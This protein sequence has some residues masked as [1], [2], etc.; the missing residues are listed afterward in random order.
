MPINDELRLDLIMNLAKPHC[1]TALNTKNLT[2]VKDL[3]NLLKY[4]E[5][6][7]TDCK[8]QIFFYL[9]HEHFQDF[10]Q[11]RAS[12]SFD[13][14][15]SKSKVKKWSRLAEMDSASDS[16][17]TVLKCNNVLELISSGNKKQR[18]SF[19]TL[20]KKHFAEEN[21][22]FLEVVIELKKLE[23]N[24]EQSQSSRAAKCQNKIEEIIAKF[25]RPGSEYE[26][27]LPQDMRETIL[28]NF[29]SETSKESFS[30]LFS[31]AQTEIVQLL[32]QNYLEKFLEGDTVSAD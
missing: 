17:Q 21:F 31:A 4:Y 32:N 2:Q 13:R 30:D 8:Q 12:F 5:K 18:K 11:S 28:Q 16:E 26:I 10:K 7:L 23:D 14:R 19:E 3:Q 9:N 22:Y 1:L 6:L 25:V 15:Q 24:T 20:L 27:N 29:Q